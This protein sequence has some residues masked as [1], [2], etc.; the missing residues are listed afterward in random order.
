MF[1]KYLMKMFGVGKI[2]NDK[3]IIEYWIGKISWIIVIYDYVVF[4]FIEL[5]DNIGVNI[6]CFFCN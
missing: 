3:L 2:V 5:V 1:M 6:I 4:C